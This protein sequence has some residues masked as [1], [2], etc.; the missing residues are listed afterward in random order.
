MKANEYIANQNN[1]VDE[2]NDDGEKEKKVH[3]DVAIIGGGFAGLSAALL[4]GRYLRSTVVF[5][6]GKTRNYTTK[7]LHG[8]LGFENSSPQEFIHKSWSD[9]L[10]YQS[11]TVIKE[12]VV[13][14]NIKG[15]NDNDSF[16]LTTERGKIPIEA[17]Y[18]IICTG[19]EDIKP[20]DIK[21]FGN[22]DGNGAWHC[23]HCDGY[24]A[25]GK[26]V[27]IISNK[28]SAIAYAKELLGWTKN[29]V[30]FVRG[31]YEQL[32]GK[33]KDEAKTLGIQVVE[34]DDVV[35]IS[36]NKKDGIERLI[37]QSGR[38]YGADVIFYYLGYKVKNELA[39]QLGCE[40]DEKH[41]FIKVNSMQQTTV[42]HVYAAGD[43]DTDRHYIILAAASGA[44]AAVSI[45]EDMLKDSI[46]NRKEKT[47]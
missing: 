36:G 10:Q 20:N 35:Q 38:S 14:V 3:A 12:K 24:Q 1:I 40:L 47:H 5:D 7:R 33:D 21:N 26:R 11:V 46:K 13:A 2:Q 22:F 34:H 4:L 44:I 39:K 23:P 29:I 16:S 45:Y 43:V 28:A 32:T 18:L 25:V 8:Y 9:V 6:G 41:E 27:A 17:K 31:N 37:C 19:V 15:D 30:V 42:P